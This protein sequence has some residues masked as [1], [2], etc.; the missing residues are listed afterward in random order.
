MKKLEKLIRRSDNSNLI[1]YLIL[2]ILQKNM[3]MT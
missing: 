1:L 3:D 2:D